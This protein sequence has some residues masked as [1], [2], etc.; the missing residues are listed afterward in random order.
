M[1]AT[2][3]LTNKKVVV[4]LSC[5]HVIEPWFKAPLSHT[6]VLITT[7][8]FEKWTT[9]SNNTT[10]EEGS[11]YWQAASFWYK[12]KCSTRAKL[13]ATGGQTKNIWLMHWRTH[14]SYKITKLLS[15]MWLYQRALAHTRLTS[16][17]LVHVYKRTV[18]SPHAGIQT[19]VVPKKLY[20]NSPP[21]SN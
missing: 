7:T 17:V 12:K 19:F 11:N 13:C 2:I 6:Y 3:V 14:C 10:K 15:H 20:N 8:W 1:P 4:F 21:S 9:S 5:T 18:H 16:T